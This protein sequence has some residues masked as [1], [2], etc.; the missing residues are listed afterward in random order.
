MYR[1]GR[2]GT[3]LGVPPAGWGPRGSLS[4]TARP[5]TWLSALPCHLVCYPAF[6]NSAFSLASSV[7]ARS[8]WAG[9]ASSCC[10]AGANSA[11]APMRPRSSSALTRAAGLLSGS[12]LSWCNLSTTCALIRAASSDTDTSLALT[13][14]LTLA[15]IEGLAINR[16]ASAWIE[17]G[18]MLAASYAARYAWANVSPLV[19][20]PTANASCFEVRP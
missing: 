16:H 12:M 17:A 19:P 2:A 4:S 10:G 7:A 15:A 13:R 6:A 11:T 18:A 1:R 8:A 9:V 14:A 20:T 5:A 3:R